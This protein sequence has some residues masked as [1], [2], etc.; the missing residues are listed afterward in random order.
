MGGQPVLLLKTIGRRSGRNRTTPVQYLA[1][2]GGY[3]V[4]AANAG[5]KR[6][7]AWYLNL[8][9]CP[10]AQIQSGAESIDVIARVVA[11]EEREKLW[12]RLTEA[13]GYLERIAAKAHRELPLILLV[14]VSHAM[15]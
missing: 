7:P 6:P 13:N 1:V 12:R 4:V 5:A 14:P 15:T 3:L 9:A 11:G 8:Q 2:S 10:D